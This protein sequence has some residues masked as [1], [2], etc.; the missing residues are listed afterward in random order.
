MK[1]MDRWKDFKENKEFKKAISDPEL[2]K[3]S[4]KIF[5]KNWG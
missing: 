3:L 4:R 1:V 2:M 5:G